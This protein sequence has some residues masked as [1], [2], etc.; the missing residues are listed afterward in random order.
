MVFFLSLSLS[1]SIRKNVILYVSTSSSPCLNFFFILLSHFYVYW[2]HAYIRFICF[3]LLLSNFQYDFLFYRHSFPFVYHQFGFFFW[4]EMSLMSPFF[5]ICFIR[6]IWL[7]HVL[8]YKYVGIKKILR[9]YAHVHCT[10]TNVHTV[11]NAKCNSIFPFYSHCST[12]DLIAQQCAHKCNNNNKYK[13]KSIHVCSE[14]LHLLFAGEFFL[15]IF[16]P[17]QNVSKMK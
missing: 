7:L 3:I 15:Y 14:H 4:I 10:C 13:R 12:H 11:C 5:N 2:L 8:K 1:F 9:C 6:I 16:S 17:L